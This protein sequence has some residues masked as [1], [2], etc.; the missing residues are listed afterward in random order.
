MKVDCQWEVERGVGLKNSRH[1]SKD[2]KSLITV[3][4][5]MIPLT[6]ALS[7]YGRGL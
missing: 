2:I 6:L 7:L 5:L 4:T 3:K 1:I